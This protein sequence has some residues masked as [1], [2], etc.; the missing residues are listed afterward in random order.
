MGHNDGTISQEMKTMIED[1]DMSVLTAVEEIA[2]VLI[3]G[4][5]NEQSPEFDIDQNF[6]KLMGDAAAKI[7]TY[8]LSGKNEEEVENFIR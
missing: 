6:V 3:D 5:Q 8:D 1:K 7:Q 4:D 2:L